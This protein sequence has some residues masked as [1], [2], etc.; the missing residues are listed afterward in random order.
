[1]PVLALSETRRHNLL[2]VSN[3]DKDVVGLTDAGRIGEFFLCQ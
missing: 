1:M 2:D 3:R